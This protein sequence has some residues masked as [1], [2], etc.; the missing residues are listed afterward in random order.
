MKKAREPRNL[1]EAI[2]YFSDT[3]V[4]FDFVVSLR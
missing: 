2:R 4:A 1:L 3:Q